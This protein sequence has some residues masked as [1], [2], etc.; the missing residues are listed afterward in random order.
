MQLVNKTNNYVL[1]N[2]D[3]LRGKKRVQF[4][5]PVMVASEMMKK[6]GFS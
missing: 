1:E 3:E 5:T 6:R 2:L 4:I